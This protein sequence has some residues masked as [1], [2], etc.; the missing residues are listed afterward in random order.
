[1]WVCDWVLWL[2]GCFTLLASKT[3]L[4]IPNLLPTHVWIHPSKEPLKGHV[5]RARGG[6][7]QARNPQPRLYACLFR[8]FPKAS[9][10]ILSFEM[11]STWYG[12]RFSSYFFHVLDHYV[13]YCA[14]LRTE[15]FS[16][17]VYYGIRD[18]T[19]DWFNG[20]SGNGP[21]F[22][23]P[24]IFLWRSETYENA[25]SKLFCLQGWGIVKIRGCE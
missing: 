25:P 10:L 16:R 7:L 2:F 12:K 6:A 5:N 24:R 19:Y 15:I 11:D 18:F 17:R 3:L 9:Q 8:S 21:N 20:Q 4:P 14:R 1:M 23:T 13:V 22:L